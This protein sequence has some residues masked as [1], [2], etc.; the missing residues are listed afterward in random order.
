[1]RISIVFG[2]F[3]PVPPLRG[4]ATEKVWDRLARQ[5]AQRGH[6][7]TAVCRRWP[8]Q[9]DRENR[10]GVEYRRIPGAPPSK[11]LAWNLVRDLRWGLRAARALPAGDV[12][13]CNTVTLPVWL[14]RMKPAAGRVVAVLGRVPKGQVRFYGR[15]ARVYAT[16]RFVEEKALAE[17][18]A[19]RGRIAVVGNAID[20]DLHVAAGASRPAGGEPVELGFVG[21]LHPEKGLELLL[22]A[23]GDLA[24]RSALPPWRLRLAGPAAAAD[25]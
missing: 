8:G 23:A 14:P 16:S 2:F 17:A 22:R 25:G 1:M 12:V 20:W 10:D 3:L 7:V 4:G 15:A 5:F 13:I 24:G 9:A 18:P 6:T 19:L 11:R 21:R